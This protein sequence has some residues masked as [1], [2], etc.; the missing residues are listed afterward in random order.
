MT[1]LSARFKQGLSEVRR[2]VIDFSLQL[3]AVPTVSSPSGGTGL[4]VSSLAI[5]GDGKTAAFYVSGGQTGQTY[6]IDLLST[7]SIA[8]VFEDVVAVDIITKV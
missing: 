6:E 4:V 2:Y 8:Q 7:T 1:V 5:A 3:S